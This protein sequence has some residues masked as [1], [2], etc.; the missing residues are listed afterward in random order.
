MQSAVPVLLV[1]ARACYCRVVSQMLT[2]TEVFL[3][4]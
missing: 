1:T 2:G 3:G 4:L